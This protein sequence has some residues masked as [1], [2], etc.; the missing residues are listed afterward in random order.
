[1]SVMRDKLREF[2]LDVDNMTDA[3]INGLAKEL[4]GA[5]PELRDQLPRR[6]KIETGKN[7]AQYVV[8][9]MFN[10]PKI[11]DGIAVK[12]ENS[13]ARNLYIR[14]EAIDQCINDLQAAKEMLKRSNR[15]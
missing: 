11:K 9:E 7:G 8:T 14:V 15:G 6:V 2:G 10:V 1:M 12:G 5:C 4:L 13:Q 3:Q